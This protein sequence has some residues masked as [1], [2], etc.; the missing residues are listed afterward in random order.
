MVAGDPGP[1]RDL[2]DGEER[3]HLGFQHVRCGGLYAQGGMARGRTG[4]DAA[5]M[6]IRTLRPSTLS[7][8]S[9]HDLM[10][11]ES[12]EPADAT[13]T[14]KGLVKIGD[15]A[16]LAGTNLRTLRYYEEIGLLRP[17]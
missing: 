15:F 16:R 10:K 2:F 6:S 4:V 9:G 3:V 8:E 5:D 1:T 17:A 11:P 13:L 14:G 12:I 7:A